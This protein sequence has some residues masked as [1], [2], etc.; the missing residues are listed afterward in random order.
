MTNQKN[1]FNLIKSISGQLN[2]IAVP[3]IYIELLD[4]DINS[5]I[6][7]SQIIY[8]SD[9]SKR[10]N[11]WFY[12]TFNDWYDEIGLT[13]YKIKRASDL[14]CEKGFVET[15]L[16]RAS[17]APT[18]HYKLNIELLTKSIIE[19]LDNRETS[20]SDYEETYKSDYKETPQSD[21]Q[22]TY[23]SLTE[24]TQDTITQNTTESI[25]E[26]PVSKLFSAFVTGLQRSPYP[27]EVD[28]WTRELSIMA[29]E[30]VIEC[31]IK[32][33][34]IELD[35]KYTIT[36]PRSIK[37]AAITCKRKRVS[38]NLGNN[39]PF[40]LDSFKFDNMEQK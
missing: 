31:D 13:Q 32:Q 24:T 8:W 38:G 26:N 14:L 29:N 3:R 30:G 19:F 9:K 17:G 7:L 33:A 6:L 35:G 23:K 1:V 34:F 40:G 28:S 18:V 37:N 20:Q 15:K 27:N 21:Y 39:K 36:S 16:K 25:E 5:A 11:G 22:E 2:L 10:N 4:G 12:K